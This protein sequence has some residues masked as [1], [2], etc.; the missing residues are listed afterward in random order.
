VTNKIAKVIVSNLG[1]F[2]FDHFDD[3][4]FELL[5][6]FHIVV[7]ATVVVF[8]QAMRVAV[9]EPTAAFD[10]QQAHFFIATEASFPILL[11]FLGLKGEVLHLLADVL[12]GNSQRGGAVAGSSLNLGLLGGKIDGLGRGCLF[13]VTGGAKA[14]VALGGIE[15]EAFFALGRFS[16]VAQASFRTH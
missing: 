8:G 16:R 15:S 4:F 11:L 13:L 10:A 2:S 5:F 3:F 6:A 12:L 14:T 1:D 7:E 9:N